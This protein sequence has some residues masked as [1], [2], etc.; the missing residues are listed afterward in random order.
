MTTLID[1][2]SIIW[3][4]CSLCEGVYYEVP[5]H[6]EFTYKKEAKEYCDQFQISKDEIQKK[7]DP[8]NISHCFHLLKLTLDGII[9]VCGQDYKVYLSGDENFRYEIY[10]EYKANRPAEK[11][12]YFQEARSYIEKRYN[13]EVVHGIEADDAVA[14]D[15]LPG[16]I[17]ASIDKDL[18]Q[19]PGT[20]Y[21]YRKKEFYEITP[22]EAAFN[23]YLSLLTGDNGDNIPGLPGIGK[24][25]GTAL[26]QGV[27]TD[28]MYDVCLEAYRVKGLYEETMLR[29]ARLL[30]LKRSNNDEFSRDSF[31][32]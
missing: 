12:V 6:G 26:L 2:D 28:Q 16:D 10:P 31:D 21:N 27:Q 7:K 3:Q 9:A 22:D 15:Y 14:M 11:P 19:L 5:E 23:F 29:N 17:I 4:A 25:R 32:V 8:E 24:S 20:H 18:D 13:A 30:Y 1:A